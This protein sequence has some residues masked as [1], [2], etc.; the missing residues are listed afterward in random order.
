MTQL[1]MM[2][3]LKLFLL[4]LFQN[5]KKQQ[6]DDSK[7]IYEAKPLTLRKHFYVYRSIAY[8]DKQSYNH[9]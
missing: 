3:P 4:S 7:V 2:C 9:D 1:R 6:S 5:R 8:K